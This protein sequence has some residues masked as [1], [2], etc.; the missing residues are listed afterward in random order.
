MCV[1][2][3]YVHVCVWMY[4][5]VL[6]VWIYVCMC[7]NIYVCVRV[8]VRVCAC[9]CVCEYTCVYACTCVR[10]WLYVQWIF[11]KWYWYAIYRIDYIIFPA[12]E[13]CVFETYLFSYYAGHNKGSFAK[14]HTHTHA[15]TH[16]HQHVNKE[17]TVT[18]MHTQYIQVFYAILQLS[19]TGLLQCIGGGSRG[20]RDPLKF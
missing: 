18:H 3:V 15:R 16:M 14:S 8:C 9:A 19:W 1:V 20:A 13:I 4:M 10:A 7:K 5:C 11:I 2:C 17:S 12:D 6:C